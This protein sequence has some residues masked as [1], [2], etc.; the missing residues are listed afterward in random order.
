MNVAGVECK[1][2][3][4]DEPV[5]FRGI[6]DQQSQLIQD[7]NGAQFVDH[8]YRLTVTRNTAV[9]IPRDVLHKIHINHEEYTVRHILLTGDGENC[10]IYLTKLNAFPSE[11]DPVGTC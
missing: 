11:C 5:F 10:E 8:M 6:L 9:Q 2:V 7:D 1:T 4:D 3:L